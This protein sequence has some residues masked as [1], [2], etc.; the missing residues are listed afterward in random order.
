MYLWDMSTEVKT[1][2]FSDEVSRVLPSLVMQEQDDV[3][4]PKIAAHVTG[5]YTPEKDA[6]GTCETNIFYSSYAVLDTDWFL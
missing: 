1:V 2:T 6:G 4:R 5:S 3:P